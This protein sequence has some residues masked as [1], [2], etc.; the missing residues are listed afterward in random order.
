MTIG[1]DATGEI[2]GAGQILRI[3]GERF[4]PDAID[5]IFQ[6]VAKFAYFKRA[7]QAT[8]T[9]LMEFHMLRQNAEARMILGRGAPDE[10]ASAPCAQNAARAKNGKT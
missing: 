5:S 1:K 4:A 6:D 3:P 9:R 2:D 7:D 10:F 8:D